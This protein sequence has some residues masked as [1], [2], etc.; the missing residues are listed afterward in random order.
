MRPSNLP[1][2]YWDASAVI[3]VL[4]E[5]AHH[6]K[7]MELYGAE[8]IHLLSTL[9]YAEVAAVLARAKRERVLDERQLAEAHLILDSYPWRRIMANPGQEDVRRLAERWPLRGADLWHLA[10]AMTLKREF[11]EL[12]LLTFDGKL[13]SAAQG[14]GLT[15]Q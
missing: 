6:K 14:E 5:D 8:G 1:V 7:A 9:A 15:R 2:V 3:S 12:V 13:L 11:S 10:L 4:T